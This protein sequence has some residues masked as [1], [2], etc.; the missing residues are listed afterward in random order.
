MTATEIFDRIPPNDTDAERSLLGSLILDP[1]NV[2][3]VSRITSGSDFHVPANG[4]LFDAMV[5]IQQAG[6]PIGD[7]TILRAELV[8]L[9]LSE[10]WPSLELASLAKSATG[11]NASYYA[12]RVRECSRRR[13]YVDIA[14]QLAVRAFDSSA[15]DVGG[16]LASQLDGLDHDRATGV[17]SVGEIAVDVLDDLDTAGAT[18]RG[19]MTGLVSIDEAVG[20]MMPSESWVLAARPGLGKTSLAMQIALHNAERDRSVLF[21][22]LEMSDRELIQRLICSRSQINQRRVRTGKLGPADR[23]TM[24]NAGAELWHL[25]LRVWSPSQATMQDIRATARLE[26]K[27]NGLALLVV[28][29]LQ[30]VAP[31]R[32]DEKRSATEQVTNISNAVKRLAKELAVPIFVLAQLNRESEKSK[33]RPTL[34]HLRQSGAIEQDADVVMF[35]HR[36]P[37]NRTK[38]ETELLVAKHRHGV[39]G[40]IDLDWIGHETRFADP[41]C[42]NQ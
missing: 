17:R 39:E 27:A 41:E 28:D 5:S 11:N 18:G 10:L 30:L 4:S 7:M 26:Q 38:P 6:L 40:K 36:D 8:K 9:R 15:E 20:A 13:R 2:D 23:Q 21:V 33:S 24:V 31:A 14:S 29:Y 22:S 25:P 12:H 19:L 35:L 3:K 37:E 32:A 34:G 42:Q 16:W 1:R